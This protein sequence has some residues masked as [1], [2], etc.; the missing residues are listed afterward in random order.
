MAAPYCKCVL[1]IGNFDGVHRGHQEI[2][3][4]AREAAAGLQL[5]VR[6][7]IF[8]PFPLQVLRPQ[9]APQRLMSIEERVAALKY[10]GANEVRVMTPTVEFLGQPPEEFV[11]WLIKTFAPAVIVEGEDFRFGRERRGNIKYL[12][13]VGVA[14]GF[15]VVSVPSEKIVLPGGA[16][17]RASSTMVRTLLAEGRA[18]EAEIILGRKRA[19]TIVG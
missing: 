1:A 5:P 16:E 19:F 18:E 8:D 4:R 3:R 7:L 12:Q 13:Q 6:V 14:M 10:Y 11:T 9:A 2:L 17:V 15:A